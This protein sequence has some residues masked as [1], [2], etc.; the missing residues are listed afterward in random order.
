MK[1]IQL[2]IAAAVIIIAFLAG[3]GVKTMRCN[4]A[5]LSAENTAYQEAI[6]ATTRYNEIAAEYEKIKAEK[7][8]TKIVYRERI[9][10]AKDSSFGCHVDAD[11]VQLINDILA[12]D[13]G[14]S[15]Q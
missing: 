3:Y 12:R 1:H 6:A 13:T 2:I 11:G 4:N 15:D 14:K 10:N 7:Q 5:R 8:Q 9:R